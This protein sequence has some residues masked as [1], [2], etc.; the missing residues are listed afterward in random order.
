MKRYILKRLLEA[1]PVVLLII[2][3]TFFFIRL[4]PGGPFHQEKPLPPDVIHALEAHYGLGD[5]LL[6]QLTRYLKN[7]CM[8]D[9][10][11]SYTHPGYDVTELIKQSFPVSIQLGL[12]AWV[13]SLII[14][15]PAGIW[16]AYKKPGLIDIC[17]TSLST[18]GLCMP[19]FVL[20]PL[21]ILGLAL[22]LGIGQVC[23]WGHCENFVL[24]VLALGIPH[25]AYVIGLARDG[26][27]H[28]LE[29]DFIR[30]ARAKGLAPMKVLLKHALP[31][32]LVNIISFTGPQLASL[33]TGSFVV[34]TI[35]HIPGIGRHFVQAAFNRDY[36]LILGTT[37]LYGI[38]ILMMN[39]IADVAQALI[40]PKLR[41][42]YH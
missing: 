39:L 19:T 41:S 11:P 12:C 31:G 16:A 40:N 36:T 24:P 4:A 33:I 37:L 1:I 29:Q 2:T 3:F 23:G 35:F 14:G 22:H 13:F 17:I 8:G 21:L 5:P 34:E 26:M 15:I 42:R 27:L 38:I 6:T 18:L 30:A 10:G 9:L 25:T 32:S 28:T 7:L 20:G